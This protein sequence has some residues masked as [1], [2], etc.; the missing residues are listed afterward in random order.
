VLHLR[1]G[2]CAGAEIAC[3]D[4]VGGGDYTSR[5]TAT[6][7]AGQVVTVVLSGFNG[8]PEASGALPAGGAGRWALNIAQ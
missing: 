1:D 2:D 6:L 5:L 3:G 8:R 7:R 4:D